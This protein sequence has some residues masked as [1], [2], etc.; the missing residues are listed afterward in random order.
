M[1]PRFEPKEPVQLNPPKDDPITLEELAAANGQFFS[2]TCR[3]I[4]GLHGS[5]IF[6]KSIFRIRS[7]QNSWCSRMKTPQCDYEYMA[8]HSLIGRNWRQMLCCHQGESV[9]NAHHNVMVD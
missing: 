9:V 6:N 8:D 1:A 4:N 3:V 7:V 5:K 2:N